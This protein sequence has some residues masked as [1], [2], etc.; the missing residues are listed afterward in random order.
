MIRWMYAFIDRPMA[1]L[2]AALAFWSTVTGNAVSGRR[3]EHG[4]FATLLPDGADAC[5]KVQ[6]V[7][8]GGGAHLDLAVADPMAGIDAAERLGAT[9]ATG[10][11]GWAVMRSPGGQL[12]CVVPWRGEATRPPVVD[13]PG[14]TR[15]RVDQVC[16]DIAPTAYPVE[17]DFWRA[18][19]EWEFRPGA[20]P[21]FGV[22]RPPTAM[23]V[24]ILLQR[25]EADRPASAHPDIA[26]SNV[27][28]MRAWH[29][30]CG[31]SVVAR[32]ERWTVMRDPAGG[33]YCL[34]TRDPDTGT[35]PG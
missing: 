33:L 19:T 30:A 7:G 15:S 12:F 25:L 32:H 8:D 26:C 35:L 27:D 29:E 10:H 3:G 14:G 31:A 9:V 13:H 16:L 24:R 2:D 20:R 23:P 17:V 28:A 5:L 21:E 1:R 22:L 34:T 4:E 18:L 6:G 11:D